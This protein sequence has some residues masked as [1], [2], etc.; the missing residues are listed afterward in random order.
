MTVPPQ[1][2][3]NIRHIGI[4]SYD[5]VKHSKSGHKGFST[6]APLNLNPSYNIQVPHR[7]V[8]TPRL[9]QSSVTLRPIPGWC[10]VAQRTHSAESRQ[11]RLYH[12]ARSA[13]AVHMQNNPEVCRAR[14]VIKRDSDGAVGERSNIT[15]SP[16]FLTQV[17]S[18]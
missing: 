18:V 14:L 12:E 6:F 16:S 1:V 9:R 4:L 11:S 3:G 17:A 5:L 2:Q 8:L 13:A 7:Y 10:D 15:P